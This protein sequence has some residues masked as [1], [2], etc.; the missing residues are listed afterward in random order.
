[1]VSTYWDTGWVD[2]GV[3]WFGKPSAALVSPVGSRDI[4]PTH[5]S[6]RSGREQR[7]LPHGGDFAGK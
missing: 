4:A 1:M 6:G 3:T 5:S 7:R 2:L